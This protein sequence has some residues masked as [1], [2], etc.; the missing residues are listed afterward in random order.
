MFKTNGSK[1][2]EYLING[3]ARASE[4]NLKHCQKNISLNE[5]ILKTLNNRSVFGPKKPKTS[6]KKCQKTA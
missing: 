6:R 2:E 4:G 5:S 1:R 3:T